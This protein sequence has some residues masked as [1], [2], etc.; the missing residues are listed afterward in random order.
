MKKNGRISSVRAA[1]KIEN[2]PDYAKDA[3]TI[4]ESLMK[5]YGTENDPDCKKILNSLVNSIFIFIINFVNK[6]DHL[7]AVMMVSKILEK[8][9]EESRKID[10]E[11]K[12]NMIGNQ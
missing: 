11:E 12:I 1:E 10:E 7:D 6:D 2:Y 5:K 4:I 3:K 9:L 8:S